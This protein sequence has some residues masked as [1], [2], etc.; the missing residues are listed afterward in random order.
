[1]DHWTWNPSLARNAKKKNDDD[2]VFVIY[3]SKENLTSNWR[4][5]LSVAHIP[6]LAHTPLN[7]KRKRRRAGHIRSWKV[8]GSFS[9]TTFGRDKLNRWKHLRCVQNIPI[10]IDWCVTRSFLIRSWP[11]PWPWPGS[12][13]QHD[14]LRSKHSLFDASWRNNYD[15]DKTNVLPL[16]GEELLMKNF[17]R[18]KTI[19]RDSAFY[20]LNR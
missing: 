4:Y 13:F 3:Q 9:A 1:M 15:A 14:M 17:F 18:K 11:W 19:F 12:N 6:R 5:L 20:R 2:L 8:T 7:F 16:L 10:R